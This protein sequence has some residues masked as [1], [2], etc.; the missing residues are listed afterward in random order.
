MADSS[1][2]YD[3]EIKAKAYARSGIADYW[4]LNVNER[5]LHVFREPAV[6]GY[7]SELIL[8]EYGSISLLQFPTV[9]I[10]IQAMLPPIISN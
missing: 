1:L 10:A 2:A 5:Q 3:R 8:G 9:N 6:D 4:V 7:Q